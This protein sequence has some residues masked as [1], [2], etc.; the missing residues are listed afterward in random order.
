M[1]R[2][3]G[4]TLIALVITIIVLLILAGVTLFLIVGENGVLRKSIEAKEENRGASVEEKVNFWKTDLKIRK[5]EKGTLKST[6]SIVNEL[7]EEELINQDEKDI[8]LG[9]ESK[10]IEGQYKIT[11]GS[12]TIDF[13]TDEYR[14]G[15]PGLYETKTDI[16]LKSW[17]ELIDEGY[18][19][20]TDNIITACKKDIKGDLVLEEG[21]TEIGLYAFSGYVKMTGITLPSTITSIGWYAFSECTGLTEITIPSNITHIGGYAFNNCSNISEIRVQSSNFSSESGAFANCADE[22]NIVYEEGVT[23][24]CGL[25]CGNCASVSIPSTATSLGTFAFSGYKKFTEF[26]IPSTITSIG[27]YA[28][29]GC[30]GLTEITIPSNVKTIGNYAFQNVPHIYYNGSARGAPWGALAIN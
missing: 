8:I 27:W 11:I 24:I 21:I 6:Q 25:A 19:T 7:L 28:F 4:I 9:N 5:M 12:K 15:T 1:K 2:S 16:L 30:T 17:R 18:I 13:Y 20:V 29:S 22:V 14:D 10:G 3:K 23:Q 26:E